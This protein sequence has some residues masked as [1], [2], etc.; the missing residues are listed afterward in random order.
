[1][2][3]VPDTFDERI[4]TVKSSADQYL[5]IRTIDPGNSTTIFFEPKR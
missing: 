5:F 2:F 3:Y 4:I 1:M